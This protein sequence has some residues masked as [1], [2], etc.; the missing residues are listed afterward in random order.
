MFLDKVKRL[1][2]TLPTQT[3]VLSLF[4]VRFKP[5]LRFSIGPLDV[6]MFAFFLPGKE[7]EP[8]P[9]FTEDSG[10]HIRMLHR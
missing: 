4:N 9:T 6:N 10:A 3:I 5:E 8:Q 2:K 1:L 7:V